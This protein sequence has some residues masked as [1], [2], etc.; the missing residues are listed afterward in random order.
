M[1]GQ[2]ADKHSISSQRLELD[3]FLPYRLNV[4][5]SVVSQGLSGIYAERY[6]LGIP[7]WRVLATLGQFGSITAKDIGAH[8]HMHKTKVSRAIA[9]LT[10]RRFVNRR[11]NRRD[12]REAFVSLTREGE[13]IYADLVPIAQNFASELAA[14]FTDEERRQL[15]LLLSRLTEQS[16]RL[17]NRARITPSADE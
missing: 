2:T 4:L 17:L 13:A 3:T 6:G 14:G 7:E 15:D 10:Q 11:I 12:L 8:S 16:H 9:S 1:D 5:A